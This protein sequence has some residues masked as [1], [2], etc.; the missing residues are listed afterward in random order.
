M[1]YGTV[2]TGGLAFALLLANGVLA[3]GLPEGPG[4]SAKYPGDTGLQSDPAVIIVENF[5]AGSLEALAQAR[6]DKTTTGARWTSIAGAKGDDKT[7]TIV[8]DPVNVHAGKHALEILVE[9]STRE[10]GNLFTRLKPGY[11]RLYGRLYIK[12]D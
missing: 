2:L 12:L 1:R 6:S 8:T 3:S 9:E 10:S 5:E 4:L 11:D 7:L